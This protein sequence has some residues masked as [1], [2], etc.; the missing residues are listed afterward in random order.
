MLWPPKR[1]VYL[2]SLRRSSHGLPTSSLRCNPPARRAGAGN[3]KRGALG[4]AQ[5]WSGV[6]PGYAPVV[7][8]LQL[9]AVRRDGLL[10]QSVLIAQ[11]VAPPGQVQARDAI[12]E[13][14]GEAAQAAVAEAGVLG[15]ERLCEESMSKG[16]ARLGK[17]GGGP[18]PVRDPTCSQS[19]IS[20][21]E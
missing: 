12:Q 17:K 18:L 16:R 19:T 21:R 3:K 15:G 10:E 13:A 7:S 5:G 14:G 2:T 6:R 20:S 11:S 1:T 9:V 8:R 4:S